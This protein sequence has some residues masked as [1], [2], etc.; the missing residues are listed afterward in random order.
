[1]TSRDMTSSLCK[2]WKMWNGV[3]G[4]ARAIVKQWMNHPGYVPSYINE[5]RM[6]LVT[7]AIVINYPH[8]KLL[9]VVWRKLRKLYHHRTSLK[10]LWLKPPNASVTW[11]LKYSDNDADSHLLD[12]SA[13]VTLSTKHLALKSNM[14]LHTLRKLQLHQ[15]LQIHPLFWIQGV[16]SRWKVLV[17]VI[18]FNRFSIDSH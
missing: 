8:Q 1:M 4:H 17:F 11:Q 3:N 9:A 16:V 5:K 13:A 15:S 12:I 2:M 6:Q 18:V 10:L 14:A 7:N